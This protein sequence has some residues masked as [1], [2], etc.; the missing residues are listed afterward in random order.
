[1]LLRFNCALLEQVLSVQDLPEDEA[2]K[3]LRFL[4]A[5]YGPNHGI[6]SK[7]DRE[8]MPEVL[9]LIGGRTSHL[10]RVAK[11]P[12]MLGKRSRQG[13][14]MCNVGPDSYSRQRKRRIW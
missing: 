1:M 9:S 5:S 3:S 10:A 14:F 8:Q 4:R 6:I 12:D 13:L 2:R 7:L 11:A